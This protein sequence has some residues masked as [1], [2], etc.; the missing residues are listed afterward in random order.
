M[1]GEKEQKLDSIC[2]RDGDIRG[3][4]FC[5][6]FFLCSILPSKP[7]SYLN[8]NPVVSYIDV[9]RIHED[10]LARVGVQPIGVA[11]G[12]RC[13][14]REIGH[15]NILGKERVDKPDG[16]VP[17]HESIQDDVGGI[18][19]FDEFRPHPRIWY[20]LVVG[21]HFLAIGLGYG[22]RPI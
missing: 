16:A 12:S 9:T 2:L 7:S 6:C 15:G 4:L 22:H 14:Q 11:Y 19:E 17:C 10:I 8:R 1:H 13:Q 3:L 5:F 20:R 18:V 21:I